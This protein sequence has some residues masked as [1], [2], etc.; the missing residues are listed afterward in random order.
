MSAMRAL[1]Q[2][3]VKKSLLH[4]QFGSYDGQVGKGG[5]SGTRKFADAIDGVVVIEEQEELPTGLERISL[6]DQLQSMAGIGGEDDCVFVRGS[7]KKV[8]HTGARPFDQFSPRARGGT[9]R[10]RIAKDAP[11]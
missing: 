9:E 7:M 6:T 10:V 5:T 3:R 11:A 4:T 2:E 1:I 8:Q